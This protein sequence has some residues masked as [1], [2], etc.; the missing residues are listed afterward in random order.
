MLHSPTK[1]HT[2]G[3]HGS[4]SGTA[5]N[6]DG[7]IEKVL[8]S[9]PIPSPAHPARPPCRSRTP[10]Y[11]PLTSAAPLRF[12]RFVE[13][14]PPISHHH[15]LRR[16]LLEENRL[17][18]AA[19]QCC[20]SHQQF[21]LHSTPL[22]CLCSHATCFFS[23]DFRHQTS[24][25]CASIPPFLKLPKRSS[26]IHS[27]RHTNCLTVAGCLSKSS[28]GFSATSVLSVQIQQHPTASSHAR[29]CLL[30]PTADG[31]ATTVVAACK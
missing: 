8:P 22:A 6:G 9:P 7:A 11:L 13:G 26:R 17:L 2:L 14:V 23:S 18:T 30:V 24:N 16:Q 25:A 20:C 31:R 29:L 19:T 12:L 4:P 10:N 27:R 28:F 15:V 1:W 3:A 21:S 5:R